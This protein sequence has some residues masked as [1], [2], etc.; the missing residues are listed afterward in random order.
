M[1][2]SGELRMGSVRLRR[3]AVAVAI[4]G[5]VAGV[6]AAAD[7]VFKVTPPVPA[8]WER[9]RVADLTAHRKAMMEQMGDKGILILYAAE[10][11]NY[12]GDVDWPF[13]QENNFYYL[14]GINQTGNALVLIPGAAKYRE[15]L[16][17]APSNPSQESW[18]GHILLPEEAR[19][20]S[21]I[22]EVWDERL[23]GQFLST[24]MPDAKGI[25]MPDGA[26][27]SDSGR[28][29]GMTAS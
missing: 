25:F 17:M 7:P 3:F 11:R 24:L 20:I 22:D 15:I 2:R 29:G 28:R 5:A 27:G 12:A 26:G 8:S 23:L 4:S 1:H 19:K 9:D 16:F 13:R 18:T 6:L 21:G 14:T 10:P